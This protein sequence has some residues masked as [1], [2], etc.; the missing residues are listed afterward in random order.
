MK[1][2][3]LV[4]ACITAVAFIGTV[5]A[6]HFARYDHRMYGIDDFWYK[7]WT[8]VLAMVSGVVAGLGLI[9]LAIMDTFRYHEEHRV[10]LLACFSGLALS[11]LSTTLVYFDQTKRPS[12]F[13]LL[14]LYCSASVTIVAIEVV[15]G[16]FF[17]ALMY[18]SFWRTAGVL[19][20]VMAFIGCLYM[21]AFVGFVAVPPEGIDARERDPLLQEPA[22][23]FV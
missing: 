4:G 6:V 23:S 19:E 9:L 10:L 18:M 5:C 15:L 1:P 14:R 21:L 13:R 11:A 7:K 16:V 17:T 8:S 22:G 20:W 12:P 2:I 3:F